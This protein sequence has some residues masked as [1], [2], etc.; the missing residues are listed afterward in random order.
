[1]TDMFDAKKDRPNSKHYV[2]PGTGL[3]MIDIL[4]ANLTIGEF[5]AFLW[6]SAM[7]Y[8]WRFD[9]KESSISDLEKAMHYIG[10]LKKSVE[11][12][13]VIMGKWRTEPT[14]DGSTKKW[15]TFS[16]TAIWEETKMDYKGKFQ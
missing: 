9:K 13:G 2:I 7:D 4:K 14:P 11:E 12:N 8:L 3:E 6:C 15:H 5:Q 1:M 10:W 16:P